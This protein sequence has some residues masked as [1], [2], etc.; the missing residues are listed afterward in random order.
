MSQGPESSLHLEL[1]AP[2]GPVF[3]GDVLQVILPAVTGEMGVLAG[4]APLVAQLA[5]GRMRAQLPDGRWLE[6]AVPPSP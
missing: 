2:R 1:F 3:E 4:H 6:F 5:I